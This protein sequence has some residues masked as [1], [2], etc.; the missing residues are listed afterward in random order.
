MLQKIKWHD[1][2]KTDIFPC[3]AKH[4]NIFKPNNNT[5][6]THLAYS[7]M[8]C[9]VQAIKH[10]VKVYLNSIGYIRYK[11]IEIWFLK[12]DNDKRIYTVKLLLCKG[13]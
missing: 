5:N 7:P 13:K 11:L 6:F 9:F 2:S 12:N 4:K 10:Y 1:V 8:D 3:Q